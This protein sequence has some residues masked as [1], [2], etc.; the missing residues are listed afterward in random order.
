M[1]IGYARVLTEEQN[2][3]LQ[4]QALKT[5]GCEIIY[6]D[7]DISGASTERHGL[8]N[9]TMTRLTLVISEKTDTALRGFLGSIGARKGDL[10]K[11]VEEAVKDKIFRETVSRVKARNAG[12]DQQEIMD[13]VEEAV[14]WARAHRS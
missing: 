11:I 14:D 9:T 8:Y 4:R 10:S 3:E 7:K 6:E 1:K 13:T 12:Y 5:A 2:L